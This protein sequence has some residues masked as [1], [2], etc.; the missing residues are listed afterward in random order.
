MRCFKRE[1]VNNCLMEYSIMTNREKAIERLRQ[2]AAEIQAEN[3]DL[4]Q[5]D[6]DRIADEVTRDAIE[7]LRQRGAITFA[8]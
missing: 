3:K 6:A 4:R 2:I 5:E 8:E 1:A 7:R